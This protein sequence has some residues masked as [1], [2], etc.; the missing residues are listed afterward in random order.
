VGLEDPVFARATMVPQMRKTSKHGHKLLTHL[1]DAIRDRR[2]DKGITQQELA[3]KT[4]VHRTY[5]T[6]IEAGHR[7][8]SMLTYSKL[9]DAL[10]CAVSLP[11]LD[12]ERSMGR[13]TLYGLKGGLSKASQLLHSS[14]RFY[15][16]LDVV[17]S[18]LHVKANMS[19]VQLAVESF[20]GIH[21]IYPRDASELDEALSGQLPI[22]PFRKLAERP[23]MGSAIDE[24]LATQAPCTLK[25]GEIEYSPMNRGANYIIRSG[26]ANGKGLAGPS[27]GST[28]ALSGNLRS[29]NQP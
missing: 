22:N 19:K 20:A 9:A 23:S 14:N 21:N 2:V 10:L 3:S 11:L 15:L 6:D 1:G 18:E 24:E 16:D 27:P 28:Y 4:G 8:M 25:A 26:G 13:Q 5:I 12:A 17:A 7:N 29:D